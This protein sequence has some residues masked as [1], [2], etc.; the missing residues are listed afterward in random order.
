VNPDT[1]PAA[2]SEEHASGVS[3]RKQTTSERSLTMIKGHI[4]ETF[5]MVKLRLGKLEQFIFGEKLY[6]IVF[7]KPRHRDRGGSSCS[8]VS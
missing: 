2:F 1:S 6:G 5:P 4:M 8:G 7:L 3:A